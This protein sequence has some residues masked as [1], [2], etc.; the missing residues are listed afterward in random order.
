MAKAKKTDTKAEV[1]VKQAKVLYDGAWGDSVYDWI[2]SSPGGS[3]MIS[4][5]PSERDWTALAL[6]GCSEAV[7]AKM[8]ALVTPPEDVN[9]DWP[10]EELLGSGVH[11][12]KVARRLAELLGEP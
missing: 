8:V 12:E 10:D 3:I 1:T 11:P 4:A 5:D 9:A 7:L 6:P 2:V